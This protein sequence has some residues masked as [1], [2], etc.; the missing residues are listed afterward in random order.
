[1]LCS[2]MPSGNRRRKILIFTGGGAAGLLLV[3]LA[4]PLWFPWVLRPLLRHYGASF[5][6]YE[7]N[8][9][10]RFT[11]YSFNY[12]NASE[13]I[14]A[15]RVAAL[16]P[17]VWGWRL[18][19]GPASET[20]PFLQIRDWSYQSLAS[21]K[22]RAA[23]SAEFAAL[24]GELR[25]LSWWLP[26]GVMS[27]GVVRVQTNAV[28]VPFVRL[29]HGILSGQLSP[30]AP[31]PTL[32]FS[33]EVARLPYQVL[34]SSAEMK[35]DA[36]VLADTNS[37]GLT[38]QSTGSWWS[39]RIECQAQF[40][41][42]GQW[43]QQASLKAAKVRL[44]AEA[45]GLRPYGELTGGVTGV[46]DHAEFSLALHASA[47][48]EVGRTHLPPLHLELKA[49]GDTNVITFETATISSPW[50][51]ADLSRQVAVHLSGQMLR[52]PAALSVV[53]DLSRQT[54]LPV[55]GQLRGEARLSPSG[56]RLPRVQFQLSG[57]DIGTPSLRAR[58]VSVIGALNWPR[59]DIISAEG[60][61]A[62]ESS[63]TL[64]GVVD[65][66]ES[67]VSSGRLSFTGPL[68]RRWLPKGWSFR[69]LTLSAELSGP[70]NALVHRGELTV[71]NFVAPQ[72]RPLQLQAR[73][74]GRGRTLD[75]FLFDA[76]SSKT[77]L[78][79]EG[80]AVVDALRP[81]VRLSSLSLR[82][83]G[84]PALALTE[85]C[86]LDL[87]RTV[88]D[89][90]FQA[91]LSKLGLEGPAGSFQVRGEVAW[92]A[93]GELALSAGA[94]HSGLFNGLL[95]TNLPALELEHLAVSAAWSNG[96]AEFTVALAAKGA[97]PVKEDLLSSSAGKGTHGGSGRGKIEISAKVNAV[98]GKGGLTISNL[99][100]LTTNSPT[101]AAHG[102][103]PIK[104]VPGARNGLVQVDPVKSMQFEA[105]AAPQSLV[106]AEL[107]RLTGASLASPELKLELS[108]TWA[109]P[110]GS[111]VV[112]VQ[113]LDFKR[114]GA[115]MPALNDLHLRIQFQQGLLK[116]VH[117]EMLV[118]GQ[119]VTF[120]GQL[121]LGE[122]FWQRLRL[123]KRFPW[124]RVS[125]E[126]RIP[127]AELAAFEPLFP[128]L[129]S[130]QGR[131]RAE[132]TLSP[133][134]RLGGGILIQNARTRPIGNFGPIRDV[135][136]RLVFAGRELELKN[137]SAQIAGSPLTIEGKADLRGTKWL[138]GKLPPF[139]L[140]IR[141][142]DVPLARHSDFIIRSD[143]DLRVAKTNGA[144]P[145][146]S[147]T[148]RLRDSFFLSNLGLL[149]PGKLA[150]PAQRPP[151]FSIGDPE[152]ASWR[153]ALSV[154]GVRFLKIN[155][156]VFDGQAS[157]SLKLQGTL[158]DPIALGGVSL[159]SGVVRFPFASFQV[160]QGLVTL[161]S[162]DPY[163]PQLTVHATSRQFGYDLRL[164]V[165]GPADT[166]VIQFTSNPPLSS[167]QILVMVT[168]GQ[169]PQGTF[170]LTP[171]QRAQTVALFL[172]RDL[173]SK[174]GLGELGQQRLIIHSG[175]DISEQ[176]RP[177]Y[178]VEYKLTPN[179]ALVGEYDRFGDFNAGVKWRVYSK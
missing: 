110:K 73:W 101:F 77:S 156:P 173:L 98:G 140:K 82:T 157:C 15:D 132:L 9:Y 116:L 91:T 1:M 106:W 30:P 26:V 179:W 44:P 23:V 170:T 55:T 131:L 90:N 124:E 167:Q 177:T 29:R 120:S 53:A 20:Q 105:S 129:L 6:R 75:H 150:T 14:H 168:A 99:T 163:R 175:Q 16:I 12:T 133:G 108:G 136:V 48:P 57:S 40:G 128:T 63:A 107:S 72:L 109:K 84:H 4:L 151:Y 148:V 126:I 85:P 123:E 153:I 127:D 158:K 160:Q 171:Q 49:R 71:S 137:V 70:F 52:Q 178:D 176:G 138:S 122:D 100:L 7:R 159:D 93:R 64:S 22:P 41:P 36:S 45:L 39:N 113:A 125:G 96:P 10:A 94:I 169:M 3:V 104:L 31:V 60:T 33:A 67:S 19:W 79:A 146:V 114:A 51:S 155:T 43:P 97:L 149:V 147:G 68:P 62:D 27:N 89:P 69:S 78:K 145:L 115:T 111:L 38:L 74:N 135:N 103:L 154:E 50:L 139:Q 86:A 92:P 174:L 56:R 8:G 162:Q 152:L 35:L 24:T 37:L 102:F 28:T 87:K 18:K 66:D 166:P 58:Q 59:L 46:W 81:E 61:F 34:L 141:G 25:Q 142:T 17:T 134:G 13:R 11:V 164:E 47:H 119:P 32:K 117:G 121:P 83:N 88:A 65:L 76:N 80:A 172:G 130:P 21:S 161:S 54:F 95:R 2:A 165:T 42:T 112:G 5:A 143:L 118:Q 144:P